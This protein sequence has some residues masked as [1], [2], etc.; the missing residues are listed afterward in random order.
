MQIPNNY[1]RAR[2]SMVYMMT[3]NGSNESSH[4]LLQGHKWNAHL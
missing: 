3:N 1:F 4:C 2:A